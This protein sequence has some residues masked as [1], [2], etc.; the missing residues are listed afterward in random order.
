MTTL[1]NAIIRL[2]ELS[3]LVWLY[4]VREVLYIQIVILQITMNIIRYISRL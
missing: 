4:T 1:T 3:T 2:K